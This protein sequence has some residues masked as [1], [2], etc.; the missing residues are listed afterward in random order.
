VAQAD[1]N[2]PP[3]PRPLDV[4]VPRAPTEDGKGV[5]VV[6][7]TD[8]TLEVGEVRPIE[9]GKPLHGDVVKLT[10]RQDLP[11]WNVEVL[12]RRERRP[13]EPPPPPRS[14]P[15]QIATAAYR[16]NWQAVFGEAAEPAE[17]AGDPAPAPA[18]AEL[19]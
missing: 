15:P 13:S 12:V 5:Q 10:P 11:A 4:V 18:P 8:A 14:G 7:L 6:R 9:A 2:D 19:N 16:E 1:D 3:R 17:Q